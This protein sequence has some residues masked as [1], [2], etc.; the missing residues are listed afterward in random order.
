MSTDCDV[1]KNVHGFVLWRGVGVN[2]YGYK[3]LL[4]AIISITW[5]V[6]LTEHA[7]FHSSVNSLVFY[8]PLVPIIYHPPPVGGGGGAERFPCS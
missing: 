2:S 6:Q 5:L 3:M 8:S 7:R 4:A 1:Q